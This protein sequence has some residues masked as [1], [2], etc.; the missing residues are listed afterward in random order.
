MD[1]RYIVK[2]T[3]GKTVC[4]VAYKAQAENIAKAYNGEII[5]KIIKWSDLFYCPETDETIPFQAVLSGFIEY[6][7]DA[8]NV[9]DLEDA[10]AEYNAKNGSDISMLDMYL[11]RE[12][13]AGN[14]EEV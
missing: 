8:D 4:N 2:T 1:A 6:C 13:S 5:E 3:D 9:E 12:I 7:E 11:L 10:T 14:L